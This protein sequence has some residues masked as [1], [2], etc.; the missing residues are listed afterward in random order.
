MPSELLSELVSEVSHYKRIDLGEREAEFLARIGEGFNSSYKIFSRLKSIGLPM[1]YKNVN[2]RVTRLYELK[3]I[4]E[5][6]GESIH[7]AKFFAL[8]S[9]GIFYLLTQRQPISIQWLIEYRNNLIL[10][11]LLYPYFEEDTIIIGVR[12]NDE[13]SRY[14]REC[15]HTILICLDYI[16]DL[17]NHPLKR[18]AKEAKEKIIEQLQTD[19]D[20]QA[21]ALAFRLLTKKTHLLDVVTP[22]NWPQKN[23]RE[24]LKREPDFLNKQVSKASRLPIDKKFSLLAKNSRKEFEQG[25]TNLVESAKK[26]EQII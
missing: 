4:K 15:C 10:K 25:Y 2:K 5:T 9:E 17:A 1:H 24:V 18:E 23:L 26:Y 12:E 20:W 3:L 16:R 21:K 11:A 6:K 8:T 7:N 22:F 14:L 19:L 13:I